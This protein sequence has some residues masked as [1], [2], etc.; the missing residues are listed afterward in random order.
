VAVNF[1]GMVATL[2][3]LR[4]LLAK[5]AS[6]RAVGI[7]SIASTLP[8]DDDLVAVMLAGDERGALAHAAAIAD[9]DTTN[10]IY[11]STKL[12][13]ARWIRRNAPQVPWAGAGIPL[14]A[15]APG[16]VN[17]P[18]AGSADPTDEG[19]REMLKQLPMPLNGPAE[20]IVVANLLTWLT[21]VENTH[22]CETGH[23][24]RRRL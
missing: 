24:P 19:R 22:V 16:I 21:G 12:A 6:P 2:E 14:N 13:F 4:P 20:P 18:M 3:G 10:I 5:S 1:F 17:T 11:S 8:T 15:I 9:E 7:S 23:L